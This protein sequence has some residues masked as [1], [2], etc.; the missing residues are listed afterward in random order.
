MLTRTT[1]LCAVALLAT[2]HLSA[3]TQPAAKTI[4]KRRGHEPE[5]VDSV[6]YKKFGRVYSVRDGGATYTVGERS[7]EYCKPPQPGTLRGD[8][9]IAQ[10]EEIVATYHMRWWDIEAF[11]T[12]MPLYLE[13]K[14]YKKAIRIY[15]GM[16]RRLGPAIPAAIQNLYW[17]A[18]DGDGQHKTLSDAIQGT[19]ANG[20][21]ESSAWAYLMRGD[22]LHTDGKREEAL[23]QGYLKTVVLFA[24]IKSCRKRALEKATS[25][26]H[27][28]GDSRFDI[29][30]RILVEEFPQ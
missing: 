11:K 21:R 15:D 1:T 8:A 28:L 7:V 25:T 17:Q 18:L 20:S 10:L 14:A 27:E 13:T 16:D 12:L 9:N 26:M 3:E 22:L 24:D 5:L 19:I 23:I 30:K 2:S 29:F 4:L 6:T